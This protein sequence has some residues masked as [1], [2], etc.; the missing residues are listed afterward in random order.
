MFGF[1]N[2]NSYIIRTNEDKIKE[3]ELKEYSMI[4]PNCGR[5]PLGGKHNHGISFGTC[6][7]LGFEYQ[8]CTHCNCDYKYRR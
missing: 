3:R 5:N 4:C 8:T 6:D 7:D 2:K 1:K